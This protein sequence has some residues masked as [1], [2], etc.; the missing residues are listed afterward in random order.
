MKHRIYGLALFLLCAPA[1]AQESSIPIADARAVFAQ[2]QSLCETDGGRLWGASLCAPIMLVDPNTRRIVAS[3]ADAKGALR[4][5]D[6]V[7]VGELPAEANAANTA[8]EWSGTR[9]TQMVWPLPEDDDARGTLIAHELFH[10]LQPDL[11]IA[12]AKGGENPHL[13]TLEG[14]YTLQLEW[15]ALAKALQADS[16]AAKRAAAADA[17]AFRAERYRRFPEARVDEAALE[18]NEGL[19]E[20]T[21]A[22]IGNAT[23]QARL[24]TALND[25]QAHV[26]DPSFVRSFAYATGPAY[27]M[28]LD[29]F[30]PGWRKRLGGAPSDL[31]TRLR[32]AARIE[33]P[34]GEAVLAAAAA[35]YDGAALRATETVR[36][37][38]RL[39][40][41][42]RNRARFVDGPVLT[43]A[44]VHMSVQFN[45]SNLQPLDGVGT[46][47]PTMRVTD[48]W[49]TLEVADGAVMR[50][51]WKA[52]ILAAPDN[53]G[54]ALQGPGWKLTLKP[55][56][57]LAPGERAGDYVL[58]GP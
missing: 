58:K 46:V 53:A 8:T 4:A 44:L 43:L 42:A 14:R 57:A 20:Y 34:A 25:L 6:G 21:G 52:V 12:S 32:D 38:K 56:W 23:P 26:G 17:L 22:M 7:F 2:A 41:L 45:P 49:G 11:P 31:G 39:A 3:Q 35:R 33:I 50:S 13:D 27:G 55:G 51:D 10:R 19:A 40:Q 5:Q 47:Y 36:E 37:Q 54:T 18:I 28:L 48:D 24:R 15:R 29:D 30:A 9:W 16:R 1:F